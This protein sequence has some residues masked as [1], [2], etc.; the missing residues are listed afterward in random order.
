MPG[1]RAKVGDDEGE[2]PLA[3]TG[4][5][6]G[7]HVPVRAARCDTPDNTQR[8]GSWSGSLTASLAIAR[9]ARANCSP[10][11]ANH[12]VGAGAQR[13]DTRGAPVGGI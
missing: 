2:I 10:D 8:C 5:A 4:L 13:W 7:T 3:R 1:L 6:A 11:C 12:T 9:I